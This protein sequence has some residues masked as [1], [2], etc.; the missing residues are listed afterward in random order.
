MRRL[1]ELE[2]LNL[3]FLGVSDLVKL[4]WLFEFFNL[5]FFEELFLEMN[6]SSLSAFKTYPFSPKR[7]SSPDKYKWRSSGFWLL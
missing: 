6:E 7:S 3:L 5:R 1:T 2:R 4:F